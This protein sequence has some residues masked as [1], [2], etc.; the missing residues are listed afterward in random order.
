LLSTQIAQELRRGVG[1]LVGTW[2]VMRVREHVSTTHT[3][4]LNEQSPNYAKMSKG[5]N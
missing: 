4:R 2:I 5:K 1:W 3:E